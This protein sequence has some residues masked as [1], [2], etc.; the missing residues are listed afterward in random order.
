MDPLDAWRD[1]LERILTAHAA[2]PYANVPARTM[3]VF[4]RARDHYLL[5]DEGW[6][7]SARI[8]GTLVHVDIIDGRIWIQYDGT[9]HGV[10]NELIEAGVPKE[11]IVLGFQPPDV[12]PHTG[13]AA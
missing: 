6:R 7:G 13:F 10:A 3:P 8:H 1:A 9:E 5:V 2:I 4:D 11:R 12:R